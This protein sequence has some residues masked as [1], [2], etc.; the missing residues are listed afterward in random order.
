MQH[1]PS[2]DYIQKYTG[3]SAAPDTPTATAM[4]VA[5]DSKEPDIGKVFLSQDNGY[6]QG[7]EPS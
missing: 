6:L 3:I 7:F 2:E 4:L 1:L 5:A